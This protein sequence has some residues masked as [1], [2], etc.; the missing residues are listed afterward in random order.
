V[1][2]KQAVGREGRL[3]RA[4]CRAPRKS[5]ALQGGDAEFHPDIANHVSDKEMFV[6]IN[7]SGTGNMTFEEF[8]GYFDASVD[9]IGL[10]AKF[11]V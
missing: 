8:V 9:D 1:F 3:M 7:A 11:D 10:K 4:V 2:L 6:T 5:L